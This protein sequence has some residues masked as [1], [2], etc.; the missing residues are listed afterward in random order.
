MA[1]AGNVV[2]A[3]MLPVTVGVDIIGVR[4]VESYAGANGLVDDDGGYGR[5]A[6]HLLRRQALVKKMP[7]TYIRP[8]VT[9][10]HSISERELTSVANIVVEFILVNLLPSFRRLD[11]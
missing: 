11:H 10:T 1:S 7:F 5:R 6:A 4:P 8:L 3:P 9:Q 2:A